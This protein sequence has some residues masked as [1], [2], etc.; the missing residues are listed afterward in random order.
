MARKPMVTRTITTTKVNALCLDVLTSEPCNKVAVLPRTYK[1]D[2][3]LLKKTQEL[4]ETD[5]LKVV[6]IVDKEEVET[7][8]GMTEQDFIE[9]AVVLDP[10]TRKPESEE[11]EKEAVE[12]DAE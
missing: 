4:I 10:E 6:H 8:Y 2:K 5:N 1:D 12:T 7:L 11:P 3:T 9:K